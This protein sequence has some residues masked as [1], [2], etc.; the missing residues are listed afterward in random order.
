MLRGLMELA[1]MRLLRDAPEYGLEILDRLRRDAGLHLAEGTIYPLLHR[2]ESAGAIRSEWRLGE[3]GARPRRY[4]A[5]TDR[6]AA[7]LEA[8]AGEWRR[9]SS[10]LTSFLES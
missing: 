2:L 6:G 8:L 1:L 4:Y 9:V 5:L 10:A 7:E 3:G